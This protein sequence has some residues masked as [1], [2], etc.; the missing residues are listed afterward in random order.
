MALT[1]APADQ[2]AVRL[3]HE[4]NLTVQAFLQIAPMTPDEVIGVLAYC[5]GFGIAMAPG[6]HTKGELREMAEA[7][8]RHGMQ[9]GA[10]MASS[11][12]LPP[13]MVPQ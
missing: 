12:I 8:I 4:L 6:P 3:A 5:A 11:L 10:G 2:K 1:H 9:N 7:N 13:S